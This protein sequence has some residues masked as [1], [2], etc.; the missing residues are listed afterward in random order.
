MI[1]YKTNYVT[2]EDFE[3]EVIKNGAKIY[4]NQEELSTYVNERYLQYV[5][6]LEFLDENSVR[7]YGE[8]V[9]DEEIPAPF[10]AVIEFKYEVYPVKDLYFRIII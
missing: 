8:G 4:L 5:I 9:Y 2:Y 6:E 10:R 7:L 3:Y 1:K